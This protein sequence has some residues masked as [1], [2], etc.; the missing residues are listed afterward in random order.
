AQRS[1]PS[2]GC[3]PMERCPF[4]QGELD[5]S[6]QRCRQCGRTTSAEP[7]APVSPTTV[8]ANA[9]SISCPNCGATMPAGAHFCGACG[10]TF[11]PSAKAIG[12]ETV[13]HQLR[14]APAALER[15]HLQEQP[16]SL[17]EPEHSKSDPPR[18]A[19]AL[20]EDAPKAP[21]QPNQEE[22]GHTIS[23]R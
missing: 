22:P 20:Q 11:S 19:V 18:T 2:G 23:P 8:T 9:S 7:P 1:F 15:Q 21:D 14:Q 13:P 4:C 3:L 10:A 16:G 6:T 17:A 12:T 5:P